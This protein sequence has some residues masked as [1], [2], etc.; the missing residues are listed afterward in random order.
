MDSQVS[1]A[2]LDQ[3]QRD[4]FR[5][6]PAHLNPSNGLVR[7]SSQEHTP[8]SIAAV[9]FALSCYPVAVFNA[10]MSRDEALKHTLATLRFFDKLE[11][12]EKPDAG[13]WRGFF[14]HFI[15]MN[16]GRRAWNCELSTIDTALLLAGMLTAAQYFDGENDDEREVRSTA[17]AINERVDWRWAQNHGAA[18][19]L[20]WTPENG[21]ISYRWIGYSEALLLYALALGST[22]PEISSKAYAEWISGYRW[23]RY[24]GQE[25]V[26]A[27][28]LF[29]HQFSHIW[30]DFRGIQDEYMREHHSDYFE[31]SRRAT[32]VH[33]EYAIRNPRHFR[34]YHGQIWGLTASHGP[35]PCEREVHGRR[36]KFYDYRAR[37]APHGPDDGTV[38]PWAAIA[39]LPFAPDIVLPTIQQFDAHDIKC[40][41][42]GGFGFFSSFNPTFHVQAGD[43]GWVSKL[44][45]AINQGPIVL[46]LENYQTDMIW[47]LMRNCAPIVR[48]LQRAG[49]SGGWLRGM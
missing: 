24:Y 25:Y 34:D 31:N 15:D 21:F 18:I 23:R 8:C 30:I 4:S 5:F 16:D 32:H 9:G 28:P 1:Q 46:M 27:G 26:Y 7:D 2:L 19:S 49:F 12:S 38:A 11:Q 10:W 3:V 22:S 45:L 35:G 6:F 48:G 29:I 42:R 39:S 41:Q 13:G 14:Y 17:A 43:A 20:G 36:R 33:R 40:N 37:G 47:K 44:H